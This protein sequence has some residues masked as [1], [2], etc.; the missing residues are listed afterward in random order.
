MTTPSPDSEKTARIESTDERPARRHRGAES[1][2]APGTIIAGRYRIAG[3]LGSGGMG[4]VYRA[5]DTKLDQPV[6]LKFLP[7]RLARDPILLGRLHDEVRLGR[8]I[9]HPNVCRI[10]DIVDWE[11]AHFVAMEYVDGEDLSK[12]LRRIGRLAHDKA[13]DIARGIAAGLMAAH[14]KGILHR[15]LKPANIMIDSRG[16]ARIMDFGLALSDDDDDGTIAGT[17]AYMAPE[18]LQGAQAT[19]QS[20]LYSLGLVMY[21]LFTG[22]AAHTARTL[23]ER[24]RDASSEITTP[25]SIIRDLDPAVER[26]ILRCLSHDPAHRPGSAREVILALPGGDP[27]AAAMAAGETPSPRVVAA[28]GSE[29][30][31]RPRTA[32]PLLGA[33]ILLLAL[34]LL[35]ASEG[36]PLQAW[37]LNT[38]PELQRVRATELLRRFGLPEQPFRAAGFEEKLTYHAWVYVNDHTQTKWERF[39]RGLPRVSFWLREEP[40]PVLDLRAG[41]SNL[42]PERLYP[43]LTP[44]A[45]AIEIDSRGKL[46]SLQAV[47]VESWKARPLDWNGLLDAA[48]FRGAALA[49]AEPRLIP[50]AFADARAAWN[51]KHPDDG[52]PIRVE[53]AA[54]RGVPVFF[55][56][57]APWDEKDVR[58]QVPFGGS[59]FSGAIFLIGLSAITVG[60]VLAWRNLRLRRGDRQAAVRIGLTLFLLSAVGQLILA[61]HEPVFAHELAIVETSL[62][63]SLFYGVV[64]ALLYIAVEPF[65]RRRWP[66]R[67]ISWARLVAGKWRDPMIGRDVLI[68][69]I[70]GLFNATAS[71]YASKL[72]PFIKGE[73]SEPFTGGLHDFGAIAGG[74]ARFSGAVTSG[75]VWGLI[76]MTMLV[77]L[78]IVLRRRWLAILAFYSITFAAFLSASAEP[79]LVI[80]F[81]AMAA[82]YTLVVTRYGLLATAAMQAAFF[83]AFFAP[84]PDAFTWYTARGLVAPLLLLALA[85]WAFFTSLGGQRAFAA[86]L[87]DD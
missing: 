65:V 5:D 74:V 86:N 10:Y 80:L 57:T 42:R 44:G 53:A 48:G 27:L 25:S 55:D 45:A 72:L 79:W 6:A 9:A 43:P 63:F 24:I 35:R 14:A 64:F 22:K 2:F 4:E 34:M 20:D 32:W 87:L 16:D 29:G 58:G 73:P 46:I 31:L 77:V 1:Q 39:R 69:I 23:P 76:L 52:T 75:I 13:V 59:G 19:V 83:I 71:A 85:L 3:I 30:S 49:P 68:G 40:H 12:L 33:V 47:P 51:G 11:S 26:I 36:R 70:A 82:S 54:W 37:G 18:Q 50:P 81:L 84:L 56:I 28:A 8:Q 21:E 67:L 60:A 41:A 78:T 61:D 66:D 17:P 62:A 7:A 15:D 38:P